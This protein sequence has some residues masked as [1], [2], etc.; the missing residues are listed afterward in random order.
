MDGDEFQW[1]NLQINGK[2][3]VYKYL[4]M[5]KLTVYQNACW[6]SGPMLIITQDTFPDWI[7]LFVHKDIK[8]TAAIENSW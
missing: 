5:F 2:N 3:M 1:M 8:G 4:S 6:T 7:L